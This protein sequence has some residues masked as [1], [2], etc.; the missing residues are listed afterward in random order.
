MSTIELKQHIHQTIE[1]LPDSALLEVEQLLKMLKIKHT[2]TNPPVNQRQ[3]GF[4][5]GN[6]IHMADDFD[7]PLDDFTEYM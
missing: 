2:A 6:V 4:M 5:K 1:S 3:F 7:A